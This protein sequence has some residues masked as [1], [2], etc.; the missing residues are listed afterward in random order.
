MRWRI[1]NAIHWVGRLVHSTA[2]LS[3]TQRFRTIIDDD[4]HRSAGFNRNSIGV[5]FAKEQ[6]PACRTTYDS[7]DTSNNA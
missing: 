2:G 7:G 3:V 6:F 4:G 5:A 1:A